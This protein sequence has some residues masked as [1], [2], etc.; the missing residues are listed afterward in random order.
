MQASPYSSLREVP[1]HGP[2]G[3][4]EPKDEPLVPE[5]KRAF[6]NLLTTIKTMSIDIRT[7]ESGS[8]GADPLH[9]SPATPRFRAFEKR[10]HLPL[11]RVPMDGPFYDVAPDVVGIKTGIANVF[12]I[13]APGSAN[14]ILVDAGLP[15]SAS[16][17]ISAAER[18]F[19]SRVAPLAIILTHGHFDHVGALRT[20]VDKWDCPVYAHSLELPYLTGKS[21]Y[22]PPDPTVG[23]GGMAWMS[24]IYPK[25]PIDLGNRVHPLPADGQLPHLQ[26][27]SWLPT[28][29]HTP[30]HI[31]LFREGD[32]VLIAGDAFVTLRAESMLA[33]ITLT[34]EVH[35]PPAYFTSDWQASRA[36]VEMLADLNPEVVATG[37]GIPL[38]GSNMRS[39]LRQLALHFNAEAIPAKGRYVRE[40]AVADRRGVLS[41]PE[42]PGSTI[43]NIAF[44]LGVMTSGCILGFFAGKIL[45]ARRDPYS[46]ASLRRRR[47]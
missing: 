13:G 27:W 9:L 19:G 30:G 35:G 1:T 46:W 6:S 39:E 18:R 20:L 3:S 12:M 33:N 45:P 41:V 8:G 5:R 17:I 23:G 29:G 11:Q 10:P 31:S 32:R 4:I 40:P 26:D 22:P 7:F 2:A 38:R 28:P 47:F 34:P 24:S 42:R 14:W 36:S 15:G 25:K 16:K 43:R 44:L 37:H 21:S